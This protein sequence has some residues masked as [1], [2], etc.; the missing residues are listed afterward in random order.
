[1]SERRRDT[2]KPWAHL[3]RTMR[4]KQIRLQQL[5][6]QPLCERCLAKNIITAANTVHH[7]HPHRGDANLFFNNEFHSSCA[8]CHSALE[9]SIEAVGYEIGVDDKGRPVDPSHPWNKRV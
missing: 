8:S 1:M 5:G 9:Q 7:K 3:Y 6:K 4:W 2:P